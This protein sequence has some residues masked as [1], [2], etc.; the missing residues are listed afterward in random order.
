MGSE[1]VLVLLEGLWTKA[2]STRSSTLNTCKAVT[3]HPFTNPTQQ[4]RFS[5]GRSVVSFRDVGLGDTRALALLKGLP[6]R[7]ASHSVLL[8]F[9]RADSAKRKKSRWNAQVLDQ[10]TVP[11]NHETAEHSSK[12]CM[13]PRFAYLRAASALCWT[14]RWNA[15]ILVAC[16]SR[17]NGYREASDLRGFGF[18]RFRLEAFVRAW[19]LELRA[20][21]F[22]L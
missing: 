16:T 14:A 3:V 11:L 18:G 7:A 17:Q 9:L 20:Q 2:Q 10:G 12:N 1:C 21:A 13:L 22:G 8:R 4:F 15:Q 19:S 6:N 5:S